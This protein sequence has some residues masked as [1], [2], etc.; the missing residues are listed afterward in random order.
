MRTLLTALLFI[1]PT[2]TS[3][4]EASFTLHDISIFTPPPFYTAYYNYLSRCANLQPPPYSKITWI[5][6]RHIESDSADRKILGLWSPVGAVLDDG[7]KVDGPVIVLR[8][9]RHTDLRVIGHEML[10]NIFQGP[11]PADIATKCLNW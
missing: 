2:P 5:K 10:H 3:A 4:Q 6:A 9:D 11:F 7:T 8:A 1:L